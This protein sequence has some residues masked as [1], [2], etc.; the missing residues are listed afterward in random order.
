MPVRP[1]NR[2]QPWLLPPTLGELIPEDHPV[3]FVAALVDALD[4]ASWAGLG[5]AL[6]GAGLGAPGYHPRLLLSVWLYGFMSGV[7]SSRKLEAACG[8][9][10][11]YLWLTGWQQPDHNTLWRFYQAHRTELR[12]LLKR[13]VRTAVALGLVDLA[14]QAVDGSK[15]AGNAAKDRTLGA[16]GLRQLLV[17]TE[18]AIAE[19]EAQNATGGEP[20]PVR[21]PVALQSA[22]AL[23][24]Q[25]QAALAEVTAGEGAAAVNLTDREAV[26]LKG[27]HGYVAGYNA[28]AVVSPLAEGAAGR[29]GLVITAAEVVRAADDHEQ[30]LPMLAAAAATTG[31]R[32]EITVAD[33]GYHSGANLEACAAQDWQVAMPEAQARA[34]SGPYHKDGFAYDR[35]TDTFRCPLGQ[36]L[37]WRGCKERTGRPVMQVYRAQAEVCRA[38]LAFGTCTKDGRQGR[39]IEVGPHEGVLKAHRAYM[40]TESAK[41]VYARRQ[42]LVEPSFGILKEQQGAR[43]LLLRGLANVRAEWSLLAT[44]FN[45]R[46]LWAVWR[47]RPPVGRRALTGAVGA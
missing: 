40:A 41:A 37:S 44:A 43:R 10:L 15:I 39:A 9:Q 5:I 6:D 27:R 12:Q 47:L 3:R 21:L 19:L 30:L 23:R 13:T 34:L 35:A 36:T 38:C 14:I 31:E 24:A 26:L 11:A 2:E 42:G 16:A 1:M 22:G 4:R 8:C 33:G 29:R 25:V 45:L 17:R 18:T 28:Q 7:R 46:T 20:E 32:A